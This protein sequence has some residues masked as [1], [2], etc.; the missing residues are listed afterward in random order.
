MNDADR[1]VTG[2]YRFAPIPE[3]VLYSPD[4]SDK[5][6]RIFGTLLRH[7]VDPSNCYPSDA[8][9]AQLIHCAEQT[10]PRHRKQLY[11]VHAVYA[12]ARFDGDGR[13]TTNGYRLAGDAPLVT[14]ATQQPLQS[15]RGGRVSTQQGERE[16]SPTIGAAPQTTSSCGESGE[17]LTFHA[18]RRARAACDLIGDHMHAQ[19]MAEGIV[20]SPPAHLVD[21]R[22]RAG[23]EH[24]ERA[25]RLAY[26]FPELSI[27]ALA[28][29][30][31][32]GPLTLDSPPTQE[33]ED[34]QP[35]E[36]HLKVE[37]IITQ[38]RTK[39]RGGPNGEDA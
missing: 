1:W 27:E 2:G 3:W 15:G 10:I 5:A 4:L 12:V 33:E 38:A 36:G 11:A 14:P 8:R 20:A 32:G 23:R 7:G 26:T 39:L 37:D 9:I 13:Q 29:R 22:M 18:S 28:R 35:V 24:H 30:V 19:A 17:T 21:M 6:V 34:A 16:P 25:E 31:W